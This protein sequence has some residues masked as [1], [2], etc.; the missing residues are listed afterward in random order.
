MTQYRRT[1]EPQTALTLLNRPLCSRPNPDTPPATSLSDSTGHWPKRLRL[2][3]LMVLLLLAVELNLQ[4]DCV[5]VVAQLVGGA[6]LPFD[7]SLQTAA[8]LPR[9][10]ALWLPLVIM[11]AVV[12]VFAEALSGWYL[13][14]KDC[15]EIDRRISLS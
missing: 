2:H 1:G 7:S 10:A 12:C 15:R 13:P 14:L 9:D 8:A 5:P 3:S 6:C 4:A 11:P